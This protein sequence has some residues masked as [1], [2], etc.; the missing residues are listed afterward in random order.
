M[1][2][3]NKNKNKNKKTRMNAE[4]SNFS[5]RLIINEYFTENILV[6]IYVFVSVKEHKLQVY[7][8]HTMYLSTL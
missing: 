4:D 6:S 1:K 7:L 8:V 2:N 5:N 3:K